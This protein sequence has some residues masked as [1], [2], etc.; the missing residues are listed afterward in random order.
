MIRWIREAAGL[1]PQQL[2]ERMGIQV[3][4]VRAAERRGEHVTL[5][6]VA[7]VLRATERRLV[8]RLQRRPA[9]REIK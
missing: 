5:E 8:C 9:M 7:R 2:A 4:S 6:Y 1:T 3:S